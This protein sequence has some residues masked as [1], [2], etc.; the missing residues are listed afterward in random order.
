MRKVIDGK[1][2]D[3]EAAELI[4]VWN[5]GR[6]GDFRFRSKSLYRT[7]NGA[8]F[9]YHAG[10]PVTD[11]AVSVGNNG[12][13]GSETIEPIDDDDAYG[14]LQAHSDDSDAEELIDQYFADRVSG[15]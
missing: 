15:A 5:N 12:Y 14:F 4:Y 8:W 3:T 9:F 1:R 10:G 6:Y 2:Y 11:M 7:R 13:G